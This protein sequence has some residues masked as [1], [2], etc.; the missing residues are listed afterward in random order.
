[1][2]ETK[3]TPEYDLMASRAGVRK[4]VYESRNGYPECISEKLWYDRKIEGR[5]LAQA[6]EAMREA[7]FLRKER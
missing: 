2:Y 6:K 4:A 7:R 3:S 5:R 1:M